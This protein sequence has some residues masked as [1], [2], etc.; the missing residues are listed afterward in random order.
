MLLAVLATGLSTATLMKLENSSQP[1]KSLC[2]PILALRLIHM[3]EQ[4]P[5]VWVGRALK[6]SGA[7]ATGRMLLPPRPAGLLLQGDGGGQ[8][9]QCMSR[10]HDQHHIHSIL[11]LRHLSLPLP[12]LLE[13]AQIVNRDSI[14]APLPGS[15]HQPLLVVAHP[16]QP[17][18]PNLHASKER[19]QTEVFTNRPGAAGGGVGKFRVTWVPT[20]SNQAGTALHPPPQLGLRIQPEMKWRERMSQS[21]LLRRSPQPWVGSR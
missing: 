21:R 7:V 13:M 11:Q 9:G 20:L 6:T 15:H 19:S 17:L 14:H 16:H 1:M 18:R 4:A 2:V 10:H 12:L 8:R 3:V 5:T